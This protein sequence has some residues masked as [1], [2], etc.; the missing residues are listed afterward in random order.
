MKTKSSHKKQR[1]DSVNVPIRMSAALEASIETAS[2]KVKLSKQDT[3]RL[4]I[5]RGL[6]VLIAQLTSSQTTPHPS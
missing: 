2:K 4:A 5:E 1:P 3:M 6:D